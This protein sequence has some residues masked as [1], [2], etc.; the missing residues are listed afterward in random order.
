M[1]TL[2]GVDRV[3]KGVLLLHPG[4]EQ[5]SPLRPEVEDGFEIRSLH[6]ERGVPLVFIVERYAVVAKYEKP[7][8][9]PMLRRHR[10]KAPSC[11]SPVSVARLIP[12]AFPP[13]LALHGSLQ[14]TKPLESFHRAARALLD[15][16]QGVF[17]ETLLTKRHAYARISLSRAIIAAAMTAIPRGFLPSD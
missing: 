11:L 1:T 4:G 8:L 12:S 9:A 5:R 2:A 7:L 3:C 17:A 6:V 13:S 10:L 14:A 15:V 16:A